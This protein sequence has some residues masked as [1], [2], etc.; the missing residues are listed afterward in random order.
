MPERVLAIDAGERRIGLAVSDELGLLA[1]PV[2][3]V[4][5]AS[6]LRDA[7]DRIAEVARRE[8]VARVVVGLP[9]N[10]D[11]SIGRQAQRARAFAE[12]AQMALDLPVELWNEAHSTAEA[13]AI[14]RQ[15]VPA[16]ARRARRRGSTG[17]GLDAVAAAVI[18]QDYL[19]AHQRGQ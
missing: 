16:G 12:V 17:P 14:L 13:E 15:H 5:R 10:D 8:G 7:L 3:V 11:G 2:E 1:R 19:D 9:L 4:S 6:G 18:L